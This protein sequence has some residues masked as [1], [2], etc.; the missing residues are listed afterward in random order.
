MSGCMDIWVLRD[1]CLVGVGFGFGER[2]FVPAMLLVSK[3]KEKVDTAL[4][5]HGTL[6]FA[7]SLQLSLRKIPE[8]PESG[9]QGARLRTAQYLSLPV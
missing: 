7:S 3:Y 1:P 6:G 8:E 5:S 9:E 2:V 4:N